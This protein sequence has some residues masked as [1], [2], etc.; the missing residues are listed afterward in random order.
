MREK[1]RHFTTWDRA[2]EHHIVPETELIDQPAERRERLLLSGHRRRAVAPE[3]YVD[4]IVAGYTNG[5][6]DRLEPLRPRVPSERD[7]IVG[8]N[9]AASAQANCGTSIPW[10][11]P[12]T[13][14]D[15]IGTLCESTLTT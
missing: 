15:R 13:F 6:H 11:I 3:S 10:P 7:E 8:G 5:A 9:V 1:R 2:T 14:A 4:S 12:T